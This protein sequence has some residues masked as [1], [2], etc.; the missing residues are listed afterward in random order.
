MEQDVLNYIFD[1]NH[2]QKKKVLSFFERCNASK[3]DLTEFFQ[4]YGK[5]F[6]KANISVKDLGEAYLWM[7]SQMTHARVEFTRTGKYPAEVQ[8]EVDEKVYQTNKIMSKYMLGLALS[9]YL[10]EHH[11]RI[12]QFYRET[13][14]EI[15]GAKNFLEIG[16]GHGI[17]LWE[18]LKS[19]S[20]YDLIH[21]VDISSTSLNISKGIIDCLDIESREKLNF[22]ECDINDYSPEIKYDYVTMGEIIEHVEDPLKIL[23]SVHTMLADSGQVHIS[24]CINCPTIDHVYHFKNEEE[25]RDLLTKSGFKIKKELLAPSES[26][27]MDYMSKFKLDVSYVALLEK[28]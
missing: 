4:A 5:Y 10:W 7:V 8:S 23:K 16:C 19:N 6:R 20:N 14:P 24:T 27:S 22:I 28:A 18:L 17:F 9:Q 11:Y 26:K 2:R 3:N 13:L 25:V 12:L 1:Q 15:S 21:I